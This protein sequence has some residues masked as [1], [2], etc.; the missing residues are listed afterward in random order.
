MNKPLYRLTRDYAGVQVK[1]GNSKKVYVLDDEAEEPLV[2]VKANTLLVELDEEKVLTP[3]KETV[4]PMGR[5]YATAETIDPY[6]LVLDV[7]D[8]DAVS[9]V[10]TH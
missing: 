7:L 4:K 5:F 8:F 10:G 9:Y 1:R 2:L 3:G 6:H